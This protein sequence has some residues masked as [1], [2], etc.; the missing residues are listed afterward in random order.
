MSSDLDSYNFSYPDDLV[1]LNPLAK[2]DQA[3][4]LVF[5]KNIFSYQKVCDLLQYVSKND[6]LV[7]NNTRVI[8]CR[9]TGHKIRSDEE[10]INIVQLKNAKEDMADMQT[11]VIIGSSL[12]KVII[13]NKQDFFY[14]PRVSI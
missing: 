11:L 5:E 2:K 9:L 14:T 10:N 12:S 6:L 4:M 13:R 1:A 7:F 8:P 3:N